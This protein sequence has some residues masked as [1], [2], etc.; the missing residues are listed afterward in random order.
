MDRVLRVLESER[1]LTCVQ[2]SGIYVS[3]HSNQRKIGFVF[4][5]N[6]G[7]PL[8]FSQFWGL[9]H[10]AALRIAER[11]GDE[12]RTYFGCPAGGD[13]DLEP[14]AYSLS[15]DIEARRLNGLLV[16]G[17][18]TDALAWLK[19]SGLPMVS[20]GGKKGFADASVEFDAASST[21]MGVQALR[22]AGC[23]RVAVVWF[24]GAPEFEQEQD[25]ITLAFQ[26]ACGKARI[27][28]KRDFRWTPDVIASGRGWESLEEAGAEIIRTKWA[29]K[30]EKPD[31]IFFADDTMA[32]GGLI[33]L[34]EAG[35]KLGRDVKVASI[36]HKG[37]S[38]LRPFW[39]TLIRIE[40]DP[41]EIVEKM[42]SLLGKL[43]QSMKVA[44]S[45]PK[46]VPTLVLP[47]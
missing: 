46:I 35:V 34:L 25:D 37:A 30:G 4:P 23:K 13:G 38:L 21:G 29:S 28:Y 26:K 2:G 5:G 44:D 8:H 17:I 9:I 11:N 18:G 10:A 14:S 39:P 42:F 19:S 1:I 27:P 6:I 40:L 24:S 3:Q 32:H 41:E 7:D 15:D 22:D 12:L 45:A 31:G 20:L 16:A 33:A 43:L 47:K 36:T